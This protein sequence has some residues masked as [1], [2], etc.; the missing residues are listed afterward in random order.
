MNEIICNLVSSLFYNNKLITHNN[1]KIIKYNK[2]IEYIYIDGNELYSGTS[3]YNMSEVYV[4]KNLCKEY[5]K[6][7]GILI[8]TFYNAQ[9]DKLRNEIKDNNILIKSIDA[10]QGMESDIVIISLVKTK[11]CDFLCDENRLCVMLSRAKHKL[12][13]VGNMDKFIQESLIWN[14]INNYIENCNN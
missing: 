7:N 14:K 9:L 8:L 2:P 12:I 3:C 1:N 5:Y 13:I 10:A 11:Y 6:D 4:I